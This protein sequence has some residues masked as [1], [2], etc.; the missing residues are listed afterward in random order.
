MLCGMALQKQLGVGLQCGSIRFRE[1]ST[2]FAPIMRSS[3]SVQVLPLPPTD[4]RAK[5]LASI[6]SRSL[7][8]EFRYHDIENFSPSATA[9]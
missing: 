3:Q 8:S 5:A 2:G 7:A 9:I 1:R 4:P 6:R